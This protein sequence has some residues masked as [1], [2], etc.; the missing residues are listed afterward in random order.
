LGRVD[1]H[2]LKYFKVNAIYQIETIEALSGT[3][4]I[5]YELLYCSRNDF[6][7]VFKFSQLNKAIT[8]LE[9]LSFYNFSIHCISEKFL[10]TLSNIQH[11]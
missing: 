9:N 3:H 4:F 2:I 10:L 7:W 8:K 1:I 11:L 6:K 5:F